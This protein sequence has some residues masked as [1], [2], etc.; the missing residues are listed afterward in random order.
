MA[1]CL[2]PPPGRG[3]RFV[4]HRDRASKDGD[5]RPDR[6]LQFTHQYKKDSQHFVVLFWW[7]MLHACICTFTYLI[8][9]CMQL[10]MCAHACG[11]PRLTLDSFPYHSH[12]LRQSFA[13]P[14]FAVSL[15]SLSTVFALIFHNLCVPLIGIT[16]IQIQ[17][18]CSHSKFINYRVTS[19]ICDI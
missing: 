8:C 4:C 9:K 1:G 13:V 17:S 6:D 16:G 5:Q 12:I 7:G 14:K 15:P 10:H 3:S 11:G 19:P 2:D 18:T